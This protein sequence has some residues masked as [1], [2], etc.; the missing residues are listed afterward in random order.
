MVGEMVALHRILDRTRRASPC[1]ACRGSVVSRRWPRALQASLDAISTRN[2]FQDV[3]KAHVLVHVLVY[4]HVD[5]A[6]AWSH[7]QLRRDATRLARALLPRPAMQLKG[8]YGRQTHKLHHPAA[9]ALSSPT[10]AHNS[11][12][13]SSHEQEFADFASSLSRHSS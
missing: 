10:T 5:A 3:L 11:K 6:R 9:A 8:S 4:V 12:L 13:A 1:R 7:R 2:Q